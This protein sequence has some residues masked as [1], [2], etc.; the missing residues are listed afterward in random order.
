[1]GFWGRLFGFEQTGILAPGRGWIVPVVGESQ[2]QGAL[3]TLYRKNGGSGHDIKVGAALVPE[4]D[5]AFDNNAVRIEIESCG[6]GY[7]PREMALEYRE[8]LGEKVGRCSAKI[9]GGFE[10]EDGSSA[11][12]GVKLNLAWPPRMK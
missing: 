8:A 12:F 3:Q 2:Y 4:D 6:V 11:Y 10:R 9:V 1:M 5:N 7:L